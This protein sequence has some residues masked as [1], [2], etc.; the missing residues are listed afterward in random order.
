[1]HSLDCKIEN[2]FVKGEYKREEKI[3][4]YVWNNKGNCRDHVA[5]V[6]QTGGV[7][8]YIALTDLKL[9]QGPPVHWDIIPDIVEAHAFIRNSAVPIFLKCRIPVSSQLRPD[10]WR[11]HLADYWDSQLLDLIQSG[12]P[13]DFN[14]EFTLQSTFENH[15]SALIYEKQRCI[16][17][18][19][20]AT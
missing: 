18:R 5:C 3:P 13:L 9:Y 1:M 16:H 14:R 7:F 4:I 11:F 12:F 17:T 8:G 19:R 10:R 20:I 15:A 2:T 6:Q